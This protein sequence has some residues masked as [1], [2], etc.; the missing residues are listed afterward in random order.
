[1]R[2]IIAV[3]LSFFC[4]NAY[5]LIVGQQMPVSTGGG[6]TL[7]IESYTTAYMTDTSETSFTIDVPS[8]T[9]ENDTLV[10]IISHSNTRTFNPPTGWTEITDTG[11]F[12]VYHKTAS[13][14]EPASYDFA[15][16]GSVTYSYAHLIMYRIS[17]TASGVTTNTE[18]ITTDYNTSYSANDLTVGT[19]GSVVI[20]VLTRTAP[21]FGI[22]FETIS[23]G[24][25]IDYTSPTYTNA[26]A[27]STA[28]TED[29]SAATLT[30][31]TGTTSNADNKVVIGIAIAP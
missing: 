21:D 9:V 25:T 8:G 2:Y 20:W 10:T 27:L 22:D 14:S 17:G 23:G 15:V 30:G 26:V 24:N 11:S 28:Y 13:A 12:S 7:A 16:A 18:K 29:V 4:A 3:I 6:S 19:D 31:V 5:A 1:M